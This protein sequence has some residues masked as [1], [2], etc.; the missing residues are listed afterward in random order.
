MASS[1]DKVRIK[2]LYHMCTNLGTA[3]RNLVA[4]FQK[5]AAEV[6]GGR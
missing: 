6:Y 2:Q 1:K 3:N 5:R 4:A